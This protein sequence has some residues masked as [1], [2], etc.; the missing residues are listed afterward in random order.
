MHVYASVFW[1]NRMCTCM[2]DVATQF[3]RNFLSQHCMYRDI[4]L[5][6]LVYAFIHSFI[7]LIQAT[8]SQGYDSKTKETVDKETETDHTMYTRTQIKKN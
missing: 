8:M 6:Q 3:N 7:Q 5:S 1:F 2:K 4:S